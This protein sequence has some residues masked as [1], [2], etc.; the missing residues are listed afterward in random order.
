[1]R[2]DIGRTLSAVVEGALRLAAL[3]LSGIVLLGFALFVVQEAAGASRQTTEDIAGSERV[4]APAPTSREERLRERQNSA[5]HEAVEDANDVLLAPFA[6]VVP[7]GSGAWAQRGLPTLVGLLV[8]GLGLGYL[9][10]FTRGI[11]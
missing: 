7:E 5:A 3:V 2:G 11:A 8:Y 6:W 9:A 10:R 4:V 1:L